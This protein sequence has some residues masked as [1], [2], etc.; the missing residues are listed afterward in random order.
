MQGF[1]L[2]RLNNADI[3]FRYRVTNSYSLVKAIEYDFSLYSYCES[4]IEHACSSW[5]MHVTNNQVSPRIPVFTLSYIDIK[6]R[7]EYM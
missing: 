4:R 3:L 6:R 2:R 7:T 1:N 5:L